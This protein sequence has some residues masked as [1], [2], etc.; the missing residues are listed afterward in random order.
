M[1]GKRSVSLYQA[2][3]GMSKFWKDLH[4]IDLDFSIRVTSQPDEGGKT[5]FKKRF[6]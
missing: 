3:I 2:G 1:R 6:Q 5:A 4:T